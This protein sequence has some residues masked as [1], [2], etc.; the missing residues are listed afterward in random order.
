[1]AEGYQ[2]CLLLINAAQETNGYFGYVCR[3]E[4]ETVGFSAG[5][6]GTF[7]KSISIPYTEVKPNCGLK[8]LQKVGYISIVCVVEEYEDQGIGT[9][10]CSKTATGLEQNEVPLITQ[11]WKRD[12]VDGGDISRK[13]GFEPVVSLSDYWK[14]T[15]SD[16]EPCPECGMSPCEC[17]GT[18]LLKTNKTG[19]KGED[20]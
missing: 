9:K 12:G 3:A 15:T 11:V 6:V 7:A 5:Y 19:K 18:L 2:D 8:P 14:Y 17:R 4:G 13:I 20:R 16:C 1:M 10:L